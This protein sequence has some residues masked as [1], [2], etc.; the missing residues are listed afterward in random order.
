MVD[1]SENENEGER[2]GVYMYLVSS[3]CCVAI[4]INQLINMTLTFADLALS[5]FDIRTRISNH[6]IVIFS[7]PPVRQQ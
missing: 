2:E 5:A 4:I 7:S 6:V 1:R 3:F